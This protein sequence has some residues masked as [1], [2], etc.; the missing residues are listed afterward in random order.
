[1]H[2]ELSSSGPLRGRSEAMG[3][4]LAALRATARHGS[5]GVVLVSGAAGIGKT[6]VL[7]ETVR[8][9]VRLGYRVVAGRC[10]CAPPGT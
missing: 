8:Q 5:S 9:A 6:A 2:A 10:D 7:S 1:M 4:G 3:R